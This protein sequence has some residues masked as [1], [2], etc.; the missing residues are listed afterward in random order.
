MKRFL[1]LIITVLF[2]HNEI[3]IAQ[4]LEITVLNKNSIP[5]PYAYIL[6]NN[7]PIAVSDTI[8]M[9]IIPQNKF[10]LNDTISVSYLGASPTWIIYD[11]SLKNTKKHCFY[12]DETGYMLKEAVVTYQ[13]VEKLFKKSFKDIPILKYKCKM[14]ASFDVR[15]SS[16]DKQ[17]H[18]IIGTFE[19]SNETY[20]PRFWSWFDP[21]IKFYSQSDTVGM[22]RYINYNTHEVLNLCNLS[23]FIWQ[24]KNK[25]KAKPFYTY[26]GEKE[27]FKV[28]RFSYPQSFLKD[29]YYQIILYLDKDS[30]Y[31]KH[32]EVDALN[33]Q[34]DNKYFGSKF[35][36]TFDCELFKNSNSKMGTIYLPV[37]IHYTTQ[38]ISNRKVDFRITNISIK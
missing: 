2:F 26:L 23:I 4:N 30:K 31:L 11:Q 22:L 25:Y 28:F 20:L 14:T 36:L 29:Y 15:Y 7:R 34:S 3:T 32:V 6:L 21:P 16:P 35:N 24:T 10:V 38:P 5:M 37:N 8:G 13:N 1:I 17:Y 19:A 27:S 9:A 18:P 12:L 33:D